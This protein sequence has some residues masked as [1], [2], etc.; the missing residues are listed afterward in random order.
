[1]IT[2]SKNL[3]IDRLADIVD[4]FNNTY[5]RINKMKAIDVN[6]ST[7]LDFEV[8]SNDKDRKFEVGDH[9]RTSKY[10]N[11]FANGYTPNCKKKFVWL[12][13]IKIMV[14]WKAII[15]NI[16]GKEISGAFRIVKDK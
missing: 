5:H 4:K 8:E 7:Y 12:Q 14:S 3:H 2:I 9:V 13:K 6:S 10:K 1:M 16:N 15:E 11:I